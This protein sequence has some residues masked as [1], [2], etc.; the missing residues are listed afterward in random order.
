[1]EEHPIS[2]DVLVEKRLASYRTLL[3]VSR[4]LLGSATLAE[5]F[6]RITGELKR[7]VP[8]DALTIYRV[9]EVAELLMPVHT[10]DRWAD[11]IMNAPLRLGGGIT[12][13]VVEH[14]QPQNLPSAHTDPRVS[15]VPGTPP[16][17][18]EALAS[19]PLAVRGRTIGAL[20]VYRLGDNLAFSE[21]EFELVCRFGDLAALALDNAHNRELLIQEAQTDWLTGLYNHRFFHE[22]LRDELDRAQRYRRPVS[23][24]LFDL[25]DFK[26]LNDVHG[27]QEGDLVLRRV[28]V[29][30][31]EDLRTSDVAC[32][33]GGE[34]FAILLPEASKDAARVAA[35]RLCERVRDLPGNR[36]VTV[37]CGVAT[38][39]GDASNPKELVAAADAALYAAKARGKDRSADFSAEIA[40]ARAGIAAV[41]VESMAH[42]RALGALAAKLSRLTGV[43]EIGATIADELRGI[44]DYHNVRVYV[45][46]DGGDALEPIAFRGVLSEYEGETLDALRARLGEGITGTAALTGRTLNV[47]DACACEFAVD[48]P[49]TVEIEE[50]ILAVPLRFDARTVGV[51]VLSKLGIDQF[52]PLAVR[53]MELLAAQ[54]AIAFENA[55]LFEAQRRATAIAVTLLEIATMAARDPSVRTVA[56]HVVAAARDLTGGSSAVLVSTAGSRARVLALDGDPELR[57]VALAAARTTDQSATGVSLVDVAELPAWSAGDAAACPRVAVASVHQGVLVVGCAHF[58]LAVL[59]TIAAVAGQATLALRNAELLAQ[60]RHAG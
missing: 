4:M 13:W 26:L 42:L 37:S 57:S 49:G 54:A 55:R 53:I 43:G 20:N 25:D 5:L 50:S 30:A 48:V 21:D 39:P 19:V 24:I 45:L 41:E 29:A 12:G 27:H 28:A 31:R 59:T 51:I 22:R 32:R 47:P 16:D 40:Q 10:V 58:S 52:S 44:V 15:I 46:E 7:L 9:D 18:R 14:A 17:E 56:Q 38:F 2:E 8:Y 34:E 6:H 11:E 3:E 1:V 23:L 36:P 60:L 35:D 33:V